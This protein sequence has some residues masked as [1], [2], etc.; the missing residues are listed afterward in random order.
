[1]AVRLLAHIRAVPRRERRLWWI[2]CDLAI[3]ATVCAIVAGLAPLP[4]RAPRPYSAHV[5]LFRDFE[6][7]PLDA[8]TIDIDG[9]E[10]RVRYKELMDG[11]HV[12]TGTMTPD[13]VAQ[14]RLDLAKLLHLGR[15][16]L[17]YAG[18]LRVV[19]NGREWKSE[20]PAARPGAPDAD[21]GAGV[22]RDA[23]LEEG[24]S[25]ERRIVR[26]ARQATG[27]PEDS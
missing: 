26:A 16:T 9:T 19:V 24:L 4:S 15:F 21:S 23:D 5:E 13:A 12:L 14:L 2:V 18:T 22:A 7:A 17:G 6:G 8:V 10:G 3:F 11:T 1:V 25:I 27:L 20:P